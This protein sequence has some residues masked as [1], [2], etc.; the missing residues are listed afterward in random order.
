ME[1]LR[2]NPRRWAVIEDGLTTAK[3]AGARQ[4]SIRIAMR[5]RSEMDGLDFEVI[6][7]K[8]PDGTRAIFARYLPWE[9]E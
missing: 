8:L 4:N 5:R 7:R 3:R 1:E 9:D 6:A 2:E